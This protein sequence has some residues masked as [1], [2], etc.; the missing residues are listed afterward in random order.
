MAETDP[1]ETEVPGCVQFPEETIARL[2][3]LVAALKRANSRDAPALLQRT[4][5]DLAWYAT[6]LSGLASNR[7]A[8]K[9]R[10]KAATNG[11]AGRH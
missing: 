6:K 4:T 5:A 9:A 3:E 8:A 1:Y 11:K 10:E 7:A 2:D